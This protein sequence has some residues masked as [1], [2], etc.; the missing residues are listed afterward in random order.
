MPAGLRINRPALSPRSNLLLAAL[1]VAW[2]GFPAHVAAQE[3]TEAPSDDTAVIDTES[4]VDTAMDTDRNARR[5]TWSGDVRALVDYADVDRRDGVRFGDWNGLARLRL[6]GSTRI[7]ENLQMGARLAAR[8]SQEDCGFEWWGE[9]ALPRTNG[10]ETGQVT[11][12]ELYLHVLSR[13]KFDLVIGRQQTRSVLRAGVFSRSLDR[14]DSNNTR[15]TWTDGV[16]FTM[17]R[18]V[19]WETHAIVQYNSADGSGSIRRG[20]LDFDDS[21]ARFSYFVATENRN[22][23]GPVVQRSLGIS[24]L[25]DSLLK[26]G[27]TAGRREDYLGIVARGAAR[28]PQRSEGIRFR[29]G[30]EVGYAPEVPTSQGA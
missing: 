24:Y 7:S 13:E 19:G 15:V 5:W 27:D 20:A 11:F 17:R 22:A 25:P 3:E 10:L 21:N 8:C 18:R 9:P 29:A 28:W 14:V 30:F 6:R 1:L 16:H 26:D 23:W 4:T 2:F 12:D